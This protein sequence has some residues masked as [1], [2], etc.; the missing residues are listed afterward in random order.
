MNYR[1]FRN[2]LK[3]MMYCKHYIGAIVRNDDDELDLSRENEA[4]NSARLHLI[5]LCHEIAK[6]N[7]IEE[8]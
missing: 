4:E 6:N 1:R 5:S 7:P 8:K 3:E 2:I